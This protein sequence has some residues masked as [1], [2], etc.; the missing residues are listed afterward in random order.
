MYQP[1]GPGSAPSPVSKQ[2]ANVG[3]QGYGQNYNGYEEYGHQGLGG[4][5]DY[6]KP[7][8]GGAAG[9]RGSPEAA[10]KPYTSGAKDVNVGGQAKPGPSQ[11]Q[12]QGFYGGNR[13]GSGVGAGAGQGVAGPPQ[14]GGHA[15]QGHSMYPQQGQSDGNFYYPSQG[16]YWQ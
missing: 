12:Q 4:A 3:Q 7:L 14:Q 11:P 2:P 6:G 1:P 8:Y 15:P 13:F 16:R 10:Y 5:S 9:A